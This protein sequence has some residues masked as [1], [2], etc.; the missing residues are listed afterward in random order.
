MSGISCIFIST[1]VI[2]AQAPQF[3]P[4]K[5]VEIKAEDLKRFE[6]ALTELDAAF[7]RAHSPVEAKKGAYPPGW[8]DAEIGRKALRW[9]MQYREFYTPKFIA[10][11]DKTIEMTRN[12]SKSIQKLVD[13]KKG[14]GTALGYI[15]EVDGS[16]QPFALYLPP[17]ADLS[18]PGALLVVLHGRNQTLNEISFIDA[19][20]GKPYPK[21]ELE[22]GLNRFV[23]HVYG[24]TNNAYRWAGEADV[25]E[26]IGQAMGRL[27]IDASKIDLQG[28]SMG[29]AGAWHLGLHHPFRWR[30]AEAGAGFNET[31]NY[32]KLKE[33]SPWV[34]KL[35]HIYD[36]YE[37]ARNATALPFI[38]YGGEED[39]QIRSSLD[40]VDQLVK[41]GYK[42]RK[43]GLITHVDG[44]NFIQVT[45]AKMGHKI[46]QASRLVM[47]SFVK[48]VADGNGGRNL[49][50]I[51][52]VSYTL[53]YN[54]LGWVTLEGLER[55]FEKAWVQAKLSDDHKTAIFSRLDN[56]S[57]FRQHRAGV[58]TI[59]IGE[60]SFQP[61]AGR[62][63]FVKNN[64]QWQ[65]LTGAA[66]AEFSR[67]VRKR[68]ALQGPIDDAFRGSFVVVGPVADQASSAESKLMATFASNWSKFMRGELPVAQSSAIRFDGKDPAEVGPWENLVL[69]GS[70]KTNPLIAKIVPS[71]KQIT[72][73][74]SDFTLGGKR[75][76]TKDHIPVLIAPNPLAPS[77]YVVINSGHTFG[78]KDFE[79]TNALLY[80]RL[81]DWAVLK[82]MPNG[83]TETV[84]SGF[85]NESWEFMAE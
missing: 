71:L 18:R 50:S 48:K 22:N 73:S 37:V 29:G 47:D 44:M 53:R 25:F 4:A 56:I 60:Q 74:D 79:G 85:F 68:P 28:F 32:A 59:L 6:N 7:G 35:L 45:G 14:V 31:R 52:Q 70:P 58:E 34:D 36:A 76:S 66:E 46:D 77:R 82:K 72:W 20:E 5:S 1:G 39:P 51:D 42:I 9:I 80:P 62:H 17:Q 54:E 3:Q 65:M 67:S 38:G 57:A 78:Q 13:L 83:T 61:P 63:V 64:G 81:G 15:S 69:F 24:R 40:V 41:E 49:K 55:Q 23:L 33:I 10:M 27:P 16:V 75:Y 84:V 8:A 21:S 12:R 26:A 11:A 30:T 2:I 19:H 43:D